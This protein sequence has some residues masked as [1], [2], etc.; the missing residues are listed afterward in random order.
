MALTIE[1]IHETI[2]AGQCKG[3]AIVMHELMM[4]L[5]EELGIGATAVEPPAAVEPPPADK[6]AEEK[7]AKKKAKK[8]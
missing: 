7:K 4:L 8:K 6:P 5:N 1:K 3:P 2:M